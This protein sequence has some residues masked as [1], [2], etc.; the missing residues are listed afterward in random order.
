[1]TY[2]LVEILIKIITILSLSLFLSYRGFKRKSLSFSGAVAA[3]F[4]GCTTFYAGYHWALALISF[5]YSGSFWTKW[6]QNE[7]KNMKM[8]LKK[9]DKEHIFKFWLMVALQH[10]CVLFT[11]IF[12][13]TVIQ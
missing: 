7:K 13:V 2:I 5:Y 8:I 9:V 1:L 12:M 3:F 10:L 11:Y 4:V 6:K